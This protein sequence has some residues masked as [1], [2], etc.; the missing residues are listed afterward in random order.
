MK[1]TKCHLFQSSVPILGHIVGR[2][3]LECDLE[4][5]AD[6]ISFDFSN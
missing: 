6:Y 1:S 4:R 2:R 5:D 3:G